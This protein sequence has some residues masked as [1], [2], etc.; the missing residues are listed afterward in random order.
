MLSEH[1]RFNGEA[2]EKAVAER[3][4]LL[5]VCHV[6]GVDP[7]E[8]ELR[9]KLENTRIVGRGDLSKVATGKAGT[10]VIKFSVVEGVIRF[11]SELEPWP[12]VRGK[13]KLFE[14]GKIPVEKTGADD[15][16]LTSTPIS[17]ISATSPGCERCC[18]GRGVEPRKLLL[19]VTDVANEIRAIGGTAP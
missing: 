4:P 7:S 11:G 15:C 14:Y 1:R 18:E 6:N 3:K 5:G 10:D 16:V 12:F 9:S 19:G 2:K 17:L 13:P 8:Q